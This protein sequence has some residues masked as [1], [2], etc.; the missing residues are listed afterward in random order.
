M[1]L[2]GKSKFP[3]W[4]EGT[5]KMVYFVGS[6]TDKFVKVYNLLSNTANKND[7]YWITHIYEIVLRE[8]SCLQE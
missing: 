3:T 8:K 6:N 5:F 7:E 1:P 2:H 4:C